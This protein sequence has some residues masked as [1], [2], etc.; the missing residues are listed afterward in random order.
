MCQIRTFFNFEKHTHGTY[1]HQRVLSDNLT[2][3]DIEQKQSQFLEDG[4]R[5]YNT[6]ICDYTGDLMER[7]GWNILYN[8]SNHLGSLFEGFPKKT[9]NY[10]PE[11][12]MDAIF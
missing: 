3:K 7:V 5:K 6:M 4:I 1:E 12:V 2:L 8:R 10:Y 11:K 9:L